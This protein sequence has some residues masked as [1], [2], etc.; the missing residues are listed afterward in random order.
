MTYK[1]FGNISL[2]FVKLPV[3][4]GGNL[5]MFK[6][7]NVRVLPDALLLMVRLGALLRRS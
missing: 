7:I 4:G 2:F 6:N 3:L 1:N 5:E